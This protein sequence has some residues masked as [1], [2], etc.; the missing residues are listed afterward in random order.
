MSTLDFITS[1]PGRVAC[2]TATIG[3][4]APAALA[5]M[6]PSP[7][8]LRAVPVILVAC[9]VGGI[10]TVVTSIEKFVGHALMMAILLPF[11]LFLYA[12]ALEPIMAAG[13]AAGFALLVA[14]FAPVV[15]AVTA[16]L[17]HASAKRPMREAHAH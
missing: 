9:V 7:G 10:F 6:G 16:P 11:V 12:M 4:G 3:L 13:K 2:A 8:S 17:R 14:A 15:V 1:R 5:L